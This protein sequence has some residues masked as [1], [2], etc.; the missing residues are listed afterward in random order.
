MS[1]TLRRLPDSWVNKIFSEMQGHYGTRWAHL[2]KSG[3]VND[4]GDD[5]GILNAM[6]TWAEKLGGFIDEPERFKVALSNLPV[7]PPSLP[8]FIAMLRAV[9][10]ESCALISHKLSD[11]EIERNRKRL[12]DL[13]DKLTQGKKVSDEP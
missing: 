13:L 5:T 12:K 7:D 9:H 3:T 1:S 8:A 10:I 4:D 11:E 2:W 6:N